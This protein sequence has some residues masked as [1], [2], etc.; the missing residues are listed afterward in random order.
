M[1]KIFPLLGILAL[2]L[3]IPTSLAPDVTVNV[4]VS[5]YLTVT[6]H[7]TS[8]DFGTLSAGTSDNPAP[9]QTT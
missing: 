8:V 3:S 4:T 6:G 1:K 5:P 7:N 2:V 9:D